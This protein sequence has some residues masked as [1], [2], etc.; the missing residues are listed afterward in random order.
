MDA[1]SL[2]Y[3]FL[4]NTIPYFF[5]FI[6]RVEGTVLKGFVNIEVTRYERKEV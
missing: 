2:R 5:S 1:N 3:P 6:A 4:E